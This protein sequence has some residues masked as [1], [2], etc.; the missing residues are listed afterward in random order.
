MTVKGFLKFCDKK[1]ILRNIAYLWYSIIEVIDMDFSERV[2]VL[3]ESNNLTHSQVAATLRKSEGAVRSWEMKRSKPDVDTLIKLAE[4][5]KCSTA[6]LVGVDDDRNEDEKKSARGKIS[7]FEKNLAAFPS[8]D[9]TRFIA[10]LGS[11]LEG[12]RM[13]FGKTMGGKPRKYDLRN[14]Y[15][16]TIFGVAEQ[17]RFT[18]QCLF[19]APKDCEFTAQIRTNESI[20]KIIGLYDEICGSLPLEYLTDRYEGKTTEED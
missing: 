10:I 2:K 12:Y 8:A 16:D 5:F 14:R 7:E 3:R 6:Y 1:F 11:I 15:M 13:S 18:L 17:A 19:F 20:K 4:Y 9:K